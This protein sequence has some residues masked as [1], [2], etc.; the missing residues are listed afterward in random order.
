[1][2]PLLA[3][4]SPGIG[5]RRCLRIGYFPLSPKLD[6][7]H[8]EFACS[9]MEATYRCLPWLTGCAWP[10]VKLSAAHLGELDAALAALEAAAAARTGI[11]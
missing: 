1:M 6:F 2:G 7:A 5:E 4:T 3:S 9:L 11:G 8:I 10:Q